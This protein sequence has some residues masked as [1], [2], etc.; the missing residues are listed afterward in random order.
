VNILQSKEQLIKDF[1]ALIHFVQSLRQMDDEIWITPIETGKFSTR[2]VIAH[3]MHWD[4]YFFEEAIEKIT[5]Y[6]AVT[7]HQIDFNEFNKS[8]VD[9]VKSKGKEDIFEMTI[10][11]RGQ[12]L[13]HLGR[14]SEEDFQKEHIDGDGKIFSVYYYLM[15]FIPHDTHHINQLKDFL[16]MGEPI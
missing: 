8:A 5:N 6:Q 7:V 1:S 11:Y 14:I 3:I 16:A 10:H 13:S 12:I 9:F 4:K 2:E 15:D